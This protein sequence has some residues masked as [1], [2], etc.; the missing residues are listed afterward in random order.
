MDG[1][2]GWREGGGVSHAF[3]LTPGV[4]PELPR[5]SPKS[6]AKFVPTDVLVPMLLLLLPTVVEEGGDEESWSIGRTQAGRQAGRRFKVYLSLQ[7]LL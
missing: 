6:G 2:L 3:A 7:Q 5:R 4:R 1:K